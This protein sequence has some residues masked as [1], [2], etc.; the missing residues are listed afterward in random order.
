MKRPKSIPLLY[1]K[2][3]KGE[4]LKGAQRWAEDI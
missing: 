4:D 3:M 2:W 1:W